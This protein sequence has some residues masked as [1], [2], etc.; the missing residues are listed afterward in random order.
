MRTLQINNR[1]FWLLGV[2]LAWLLPS[3]AWGEEPPADLPAIRITYSASGNPEVDLYLYAGAAGVWFR[4]AR[5]DVRRLGGSFLYKGSLSL[6]QTQ[7]EVW[8][9]GKF[10]EFLLSSTNVTIE[11]FA[12]TDLESDKWNEFARLEIEAPCKA[13]IIQLPSNLASNFRSLALKKSVDHTLKFVGWDTNGQNVEGSYWGYTESQILAETYDQLFHNLTTRPTINLGVPDN[14]EEVKRV[15][16]QCVRPTYFSMDGKNKGRGTYDELYKSVIDAETSKTPTEIVFDKD[17]WLD[18]EVATYDPNTNFTKGGGATGTPQVN[19]K[20]VVVQV[21]GGRQFCMVISKKSD[22]STDGDK[23]KFFARQGKTVRLWGDASLLKVSGKDIVKEIKCGTGLQRLVANRCSKLEKVERGSSLRW[24]NVNDCSNLTS[25]DVNQCN[26]LETLEAKNCGKLTTIEV[27]SAQLTKLDLSNCDKVTSL[28]ISGCRSLSTITGFDSLP[29]RTLKANNSGLTTITGRSDLQTLRANNCS[30]LT[31]IDATS[32]SNLTTF[33]AKSCEKLATVEV[34]SAKLTNIDL[35]NSKVSTLLDVDNCSKLATITGWDTLPLQNLKASYT[36]LTQ[37]TEKSSLKTL[38]VE[39][40]SQLTTIKG[41]NNLQTLKANGCSNVTSIDTKRCSKLTT[42]EARSCK[43]TAVEVHSSDLTTLDLTSCDK[44]TSLDLSGCSK[45]STITGVNALPL[46]S[47]NANNSGITQI[48]GKASLQ[49]LQANGCANLT[50]INASACNQLTFLEAKNCGKLETVEAHSASLTKLDLSSSATKTL[51]ISNC[52]KLTKV[53]GSLTALTSLQCNNNTGFTTDFLKGVLEGSTASKLESYTGTGSDITLPAQLKLSKTLKTV[54]LESNKGC[55]SLTV[56]DGAALESLNL[57]YV[58][59]LKELNVLPAKGLKRLIFH[60]TAVKKISLA[61][62]TKLEEVYMPG[63]YPARLLTELI[64][65]LPNRL[66]LAKGSFRYNFSTSEYPLVNGNVAKDKNWEIRN[67]NNN[68]VTDKCTSTVSC[69][70]VVPP[71]TPDEVHFELAGRTTLSFV[72]VKPTMVWLSATSNK[73]DF[74]YNGYYGAGN[75]AIDLEDHEDVYLFMQPGALKSLKVEQAGTVKNIALTRLPALNELVLKGAEQLQSLDVTNL[76]ELTKLELSGAKDLTTID[77]S[78]NTKLETLD[79]RGTKLSSLDL[80]QHAAMKF[81]WVYENRLSTIKLSPSTL[82]LWVYGNKLTSLDVSMATGLY[83][84]DAADNALTTLTLATDKTKYHELKLSSNGLTTLDLQNATELVRLDVGNNANLSTLNLRGCT[85][86]QKLDISN[87]TAFKELKQ[88]GETAWFLDGCKALTEFKLYG[89]GLNANNLSKLYCHLH[90]VTSGKLYVVD[91][92]NPT[93]LQEAQH[94]GTNIA[95]ENG[96]TVLASDGTEFTGSTMNCNDLAPHN[97]PAIAL[98]IKGNLTVKLKM[99]A[100]EL[101]IED[102]QGAYEYKEVTPGQE[103]SLS[104]NALLLQPRTFH[105]KIAAFDIS[106]QAAVQGLT[107]KGHE[108]LTELNA[109]NCSALKDVEFANVKNLAKLIINGSHV[110]ALDLTHFP[111]LKELNCADN[112]LRELSFLSNPQLEKVDCS[113]NAQLAKIVAL[114]KVG[115]GAAPLKE[116]RCGGSALTIAAFNDLFCTL[117]ERTSSEQGKLYAVRDVAEARLKLEPQNCYTSR[118]TN[119]HWEFFLADGS[120]VSTGSEEPGNHACEVQKVTSI[121]IAPI[122]LEHH[123]SLELKPTIEPATADDKTVKWI[124]KSGEDKVKLYAGSIN[125]IKALKVGIATLECVA[126]DGGGAKAEVTV[127]VVEKKV[128]NMTITTSK[129]SPFLLGDR[130][131]FTVNVEPANATY[132]DV[133]W[134]VDGSAATIDPQTGLLLAKATTTGLKVTA[135]TNSPDYPK[136]AELNVQITNPTVNGLLLTQDVLVVKA[137]GTKY[138]LGV[139]LDPPT[140]AL[141][142]KVNVEAAGAIASVTCETEVDENGFVRQPIKVEVEG[143]Q[144]GKQTTV[145]IKPEAFPSISKTFTVKVVTESDFKEPTTLNLQETL[146][147]TVG[148]PVKLTAEVLPT[149]AT[150][151]VVYWSLKDKESAQVVRIDLQGEITPLKQGTATVVATAV[152]K[153]DLVKECRVNVA[154]I[155]DQIPATAKLIATLTVVPNAQLQLQLAGAGDVYLQTTAANKAYLYSLTDAYYAIPAKSEVATLKIYG[156]LTKLE[157][158]EAGNNISAIEFTE[159]ANL[160][161]LNVSGNALTALDL[162]ALTSLKKLNC[163]K[164]QLTQLNLVPLTELVELEC[165]QNLITELDLTRNASLKKLSC[166]ELKLTTLN[167]TNKTDL[168]EVICYGNN[169]STE[170]YNKIYCALSTTT[171]GVIVPAK[172]KVTSGADAKY[173][174]MLASS[175]ALATGKGWKV[176]Y[177]DKTAIETT[178]TETLCQQIPA[179]SITVSPL[180]VAVDQTSK[181]KYTLEPA[182]ATSKVTFTSR[183]ANIATVDANG[184][185]TGVKAGFVIID[186]TTDVSTVKGECAVTVTETPLPPA[187]SIIVEPL[188]V[189]VGESS[190]ITCKFTPEGATAALTFT[191]RDTETATVDAE[192]KVTGVKE[193]TVVIDVTTDNPNVKGECKVTVTA[194]PAIP[195]TSITVESLTVKVGES[196]KIQYTLQPEGATATLT[197]T[198]RDTETATVDADG[199]VTGVKEGNVV[200]DVTTDD[201]NVKSECTVTV[202]A[203]PIVPAT[204]ITVESL[205]VKVGET[206]KIQ[207]TLQ[208]EGAT[209][210]VTFTSQ[211][212]TIATVDAE[213]NVTGVKEGTVKIDVKTDDPN[214]KTECTVTVNAKPIVPATG[215][216]VEPLTV[217]EGETAKILYT[218][219]PEGATATVTFTSQ[220]ETIATVDAEGNVTGVKVGTVKIVVKT[221]DPNVKAECT[222]TVNAKP[223][224]PATGITVE[225]LTVKEGETA[226]IR[227]TLQPE[228]A[229]ATVTFTSRDEKIATVDAQGNVKGIKAG[230][231]KID[232]TTDVADVKAECK[233]TV[234][235]KG[236]DVQELFF[237]NVHVMPNPFDSQIRIVL[238]G[239]ARDMYYELINVTGS[240]LRKGHIESSETQIETSELLSGI[241]LLRLS[242]DTGLVKSYRLVKK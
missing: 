83:S 36:A 229:T 87:C 210:T 172:E 122:T 78:K 54:D 15:S 145:T 66:N 67:S 38:Y 176:V 84:I 241:Y 104:Y 20:M 184:N 141:T 175:S 118:A 134:S 85:K 69:D 45:L 18:L 60:S 156:A 112:E 192:G 29:L 135:R 34:R 207:Y 128:E 155:V 95:K 125:I 123:E 105:G 28:D 59:T 44:V 154:N 61:G 178:G 215:I 191:S 146:S 214:V 114:K 220:D 186:V 99:S 121:T 237:A 113:N 39:N 196:S 199:N 200:I 212:E 7:G 140:A 152:G 179:T 159:D 116:L 90:K 222:V 167:L 224:D 188:T 6:T 2:L 132:R 180:T 58:E 56:S 52:T 21:D 9:Y 232:V 43:L 217:K 143:I 211:D 240:V 19:Q 17:G 225:P 91:K 242:T 119:K 25:M 216:T 236:T 228:G 230:T 41:G 218:L 81:T 42:Y 124:V 147:A 102:G 158:K 163:T 47:L 126:Q 71:T 205:T 202:T 10:R 144:E 30:K 177:L 209:A 5:G 51:N 48:T 14:D 49:S 183:D 165:G 170:T 189:K 206:A 166:E 235:A 108:A 22:G 138:P 111:A 195:A 73:N 98:V 148:T 129:P 32:C 31:R 94:S 88:A 63:G 133:T 185:V 162:S 136:T 96:W 234:K 233:V 160:S 174:A 227:Y 193:G 221:D 103:I 168:K 181:I 89:S 100:K 57:G 76:T 223:A 213:G 208:P 204:S 109:A 201:P 157:A 239:D 164:N 142:G 194:K 131:Q 231:V 11:G 190:K 37:I 3:S 150:N 68:D 161:E 238:S 75:S 27:S 46:Q 1:S 171:D 115:T 16:R 13:N 198:S 187:T 182:D 130:V 139:T 149:D 151:R 70:E 77:L 173:L 197:F 93:S 153:P 35:T 120:A 107:I 53:E 219:Q 137:D 12:F 97:V 8:F 55:S 80:S 203:K 101:W 62:L 64:C 26:S 92:T 117:P 110:K 23:L 50:T 24:V 4:D 82:S 72:T 33:E 65:Q 79:I 169:F 74:Y 40:C 106:N 226:K 127:T 86:L